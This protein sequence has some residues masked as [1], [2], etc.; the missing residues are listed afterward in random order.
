MRMM[1]MKG[2]WTM[3]GLI[4][5]KRTMRRKMVRRKMSKSKFRRQVM[6]RNLP[7]LLR[8]LGKQIE[9]P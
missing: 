9:Y 2:R 1:K 6:K 8:N 5:D 7:G 4:R 3:K